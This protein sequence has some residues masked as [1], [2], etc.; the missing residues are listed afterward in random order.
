[1]LSQQLIPTADGRGRAM[2]LEIMVATPAIRN[3][4]REE[5]IHQIYS[6]MQA[7]QK[8]GMQTMNQSLCELVQKRRISREEAL[9]RSTLPD[10]LAGLLGTGPGASAGAPAVAG[11][12]GSPF[13]RR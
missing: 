10:E 11:A 8:F 2:S 12:G 13:G 9:N 4:I 6:A 3:L 5:K 7:G 1:V